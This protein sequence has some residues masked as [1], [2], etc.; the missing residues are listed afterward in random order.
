MPASVTDAL[1]ETPGLAEGV[2]A[3]VQPTA[4]DLNVPQIGTF[5]AAKSKYYD[6]QVIDPASG[7]HYDA[8][9]GAPTAAPLSGSRRLAPNAPK[10]VEEDEEEET[11]GPPLATLVLRWV[12]AFAALLAIMAGVA[13]QFPHLS[14]GAMCVTVFLAAVLM[15]V[16]RAAPWQDDDSDDV[17][18]F[19]ILTVMFGPLI[20]ILFYIVLCAIRQDFAPAIAGLF[21]IAAAARLV[22][23]AATGSLMTMRLLPWQTGHFD[24]RNIAIYWAG[25]IGLVGW[26]S[27]NVFHKLDE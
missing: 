10:V 20:S 13:H 6:G 16:M 14:V 25:L 17:V 26:Y 8:D 18:V 3:P 2:A 9:S 1:A 23:E 5:R 24:F 4:A 27:A 12:A 19:I 7:T 11:E 22:D 21:L 15:P